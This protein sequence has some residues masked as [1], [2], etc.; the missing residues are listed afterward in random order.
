MI[1]SELLNKKIKEYLSEY[2]FNLGVQFPE[3]SLEKPSFAEQGDLSS[4]SS[5]KYSKIIGKSPKAVETCYKLSQ[6]K[7][8]K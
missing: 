6:R 2:F 3:I 4:N 5:L 8:Y 7:K 1:N